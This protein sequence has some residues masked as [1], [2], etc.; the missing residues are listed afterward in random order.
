MNNASNAFFS[1]LALRNLDYS[2]QRAYSGS[3][4]SKGISGLRSILGRAETIGSGMQQF[5][6]WLV[7]LLF[8]LLPAP[9]FANDKEGLALIVAGAAGLWSGGYLLGGCEQRKVTGLDIPVWF[10]IGLNVVATASSHYLPESVRGL[11]KLFIYMISYFLFTAV[12]QQRRRKFVIVA[13][14]LVT[15]LAECLYGFYQYK[16]H[17][18]P[19]ATWEDP[20]V[21]EKGTRIFGTVGNPNLLAGYLVPLAPLAACLCVPA[22]QAKRNIFLFLMAAAM[23][24]IITMATVL[25]GSRG[26]Y[27]GL[28]VALGSL[29]LIGVAYS[30]Q[31]YPRTRLPVLVAAIL[32]PIVVVLLV[33][34]LPAL[35]SV[36]QRVLSVFAGGE[37]SSNAYRLNVYRSSLQMFK[38]NWWIGI[39][40][41][42]Q[43]FRLAYGLYMVSGF[44]ALGTYC[45]PLEV[46]VEAGFAAVIGFGLLVIS[47]LARGHIFFWDKN[48]HPVDR[49]LVAGASAGL[50]GM[51]AHGL[52]DT[53]FYRPQVQFIFWLLIAL[54]SCRPGQNYQ[55]NGD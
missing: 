42:N 20:T 12:F 1:L 3:M 9:Q 11:L 4:L 16:N 7:V 40:P 19:L 44:D 23:A 38:D 6:F 31:K 15:A 51:M 47:T 50:L 53:V 26:S 49:W 43:T 41:G 52:V 39:G 2:W 46:A 8:L 14:L 13:V 36:K 28:C 48:C 45:V 34:Y 30:W 29:M 27:L 18:E 55:I 25:T 21:E 17:V 37:H 10:F 24:L 22:L 54:I 33:N 35:A 32:I 5:A